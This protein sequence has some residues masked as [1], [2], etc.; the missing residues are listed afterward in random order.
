MALEARLGL[1]IEA[2]VMLSAHR[3]ETAYADLIAG[4]DIA[5][6][7]LIQSTILLVIPSAQAPHADL[8]TVG[9][10]LS[11]HIDSDLCS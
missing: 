6:A 4:E 2:K 11:G 8:E 3:T 7:S 1:I 10:F 5:F 9:G